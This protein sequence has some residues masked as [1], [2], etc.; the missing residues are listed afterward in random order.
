MSEGK[1]GRVICAWC[2]GDMGQAETELDTHGCCLGCLKLALREVDERLAAFGQ[3][4]EAGRQKG[5]G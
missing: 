1:K 3:G 2:K 4:Q 5:R